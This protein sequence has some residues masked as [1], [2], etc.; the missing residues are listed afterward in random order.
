VPL[1]KPY[2]EDTTGKRYIVAPR[3][4]RFL[5]HSW[6]H[7]GGK[8][9]ITAVSELDVDGISSSSSSRSASPER[10]PSSDSSMDSSDSE[11]ET[12]KTED[13][14]TVT[15]RKTY[16]DSGNQSLVIVANATTST[17]TVETLNTAMNTDTTEQSEVGTDPH[18][19]WF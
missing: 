6:Y 3:E 17:D 14:S 11:T 10:R 16:I 8:G 19:Y 13:K 15:D 12:P 7:V 1:I 2:Q 5:T 18:L 4:T 9:T